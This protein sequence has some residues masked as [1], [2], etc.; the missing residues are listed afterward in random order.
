MNSSIIYGGLTTIYIYTVEYLN[1][2]PPPLHGG[3]VA[4]NWGKWSGVE[5]KASGGGV[6]LELEKIT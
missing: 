3:G 1:S 2:T 4:K 5:V 6:E